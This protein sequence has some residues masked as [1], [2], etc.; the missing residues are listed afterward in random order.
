MMWFDQRLRRSS[1]NVGEIVAGGPA[2]FGRALGP[3][4]GYFAVNATD[5]VA[6]S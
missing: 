4:V 5:T 3:G 6:S 2:A 1:D